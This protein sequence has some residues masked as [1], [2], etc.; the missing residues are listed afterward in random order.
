M[1]ERPGQFLSESGAYKF[2]EEWASEPLGSLYLSSST[3]IYRYA[4]P[5][6]TIKCG[7]WESKYKSPWSCDEHFNQP[8]HLPV[9]CVEISELEKHGGGSEKRGHHWKAL[10]GFHWR[11]EA[12]PW[13]GEMSQFSCKISPQAHVSNAGGTL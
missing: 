4:L 12:Q 13:K 2:S 10:Q 6:S 9:P 11:G 3:G 1:E 5:Y 7:F 8:R